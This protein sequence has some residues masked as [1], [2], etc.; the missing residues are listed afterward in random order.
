[1]LL[2]TRRSLSAFFIADHGLAYH[3]D[4]VATARTARIRNYRLINDF[5]KFCE[6][7]SARLK[8]RSR[9]VVILVVVV[10][11]LCSNPFYPI[12]S[13]TQPRRG[14]SPTSTMSTPLPLCRNERAASAARL[15]DSSS[16]SSTCRRCSRVHSGELG[17]F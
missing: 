1:M 17:V 13:S 6:L 7:M 12:Q 2:A 16:T 11:Q 10:S 8:R 9:A 14:T 5:R 4:V 15:C 3:S